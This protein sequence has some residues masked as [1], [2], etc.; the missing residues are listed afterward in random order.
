MTA[1]GSDE[2]LVLGIMNDFLKETGANVI[3]GVGLLRVRGL[4]GM[5]EAIGRV[6]DMEKDL[7]KA[8]EEKRPYPEQAA[9]RAAWRERFA[10]TIKANEK[11]W[12]HNYEFWVEK[13]W[14]KP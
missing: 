3:G 4:S 6:R 5:E 14:I 1:G 9:E 2:E 7:V 8:I 11:N 10:R 13:G 12:K